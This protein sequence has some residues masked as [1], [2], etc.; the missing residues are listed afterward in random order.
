MELEKMSTHA[1]KHLFADEEERQ[2]QH[3][4]ISKSEVYPRLLFTVDRNNNFFAN[5]GEEYFFF[6]SLKIVRDFWVFL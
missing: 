1:A 4:K 3:Y 2:K 6:S 5:V